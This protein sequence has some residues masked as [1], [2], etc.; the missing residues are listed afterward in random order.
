MFGKL[1][2]LRNR[3]ILI[4]AIPLIVISVG[5]SWSTVTELE[6]LKQKQ[7]ETERASLLQQKKDELK[8]LVLLALSAMKETLNQPPSEQRDQAIRDFV[9][10]FKYGDGTYFFINS[11]D[12]YGIANGRVGPKPIEK[13][14]IN[15]SNLNGKPHPLDE[16][17]KVAKQGGGYVHYSAFKKLGDAEQAPKLAYAANIPGYDWLLGTGYFI[18]DIEQ[19]IAK[20]VNTFDMMISRLMTKTVSLSLII[21]ALSWVFSFIFIRK[22]LVPL[23]NMNTA[24]QDIAHG[25]GDLTHRLKIESDDEVGLS[26]K[27]FNDFSE[28]IRKIVMTVSNEANVINDATLQLDHSSQ[29]SLQLAAEQKIKTEHLSQVI[30]EMVASAQ[31]I[32]NN[33]NKAANAANEASQEALNTSQALTEAVR[34]LEDLNQDINKSSDAMNEL[35]RETDGI[36]GVLEVIQQIAEQ[37]NLLAL[38]AA[39][40][41]ARAGE[42]GRG[43]AVVADEVRTLASR[44]QNST[45]EI[46]TMIERLQSG[47]RNVVSAMEVSRK[48]SEQA[49]AVAEDSKT[50][51]ERVN[52]S[53]KEINEVNAVVATAASQQTS[54]TEDLNRSLHDLSKLTGDTEEEM[55]VVA[56]TGKNLKSNV[57][58][59]NH[60]MGIFTV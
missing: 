46:R 15:R 2:L 17:V 1:K 38:N 48:T 18:D 4:S 35:E 58:A 44:T 59:L 52:N 30:Y 7:I 50:A 39:I 49:Q 20:N 27:S 60:E 54:V 9:F 22:A 21:L 34:K 12:L 36:S 53:I 14:N 55:T 10:D 40:E 28:K 29:K 31:E 24:L 13:L 19:T 42:Q 23:A 25:E 41:A 56:K 6:S 43:F 5:L 47:A 8:A 16:M 3:L 26:A 33:G 57:N 45:E 11:Y 37:T 51:L 32:T